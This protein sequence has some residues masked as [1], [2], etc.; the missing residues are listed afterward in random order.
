[1]LHQSK[2]KAYSIPLVSHE[3]QGFKL[4]E[5]AMN[6]LESLPK[7]KKIH[8]LSIVGKVKTGKSYLLNKLI[9]IFKHQS[10]C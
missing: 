7:N 9:H 8:V 10:S 6:F 4:H 3:E 5:E 2:G 1:M